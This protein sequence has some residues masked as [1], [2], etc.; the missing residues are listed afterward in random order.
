MQIKT[1]IVD[2]KKRIIITRSVSGVDKVK[3]AMLAV[4]GPGYEFKA[5]K[6]LQGSVNEQLKA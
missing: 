1:E 5:E 4:M 2:G 6:I 3:E